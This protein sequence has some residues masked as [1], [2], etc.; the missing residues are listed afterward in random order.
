MA[1]VN[2]VLAT[3]F[4]NTPSQ[5]GPAEWQLPGVINAPV[6]CMIDSYTPAGTEASGTIIRF[7]TD[8]VNQTLSK[9]I[10]GANILWFDIIMAGSTSS[11][12]LSLGDRFLATRYASASTG[13]AT[14]GITRI[15]G[16]VSTAAVSGTP[17]IIGT[18][19]NTAAFGAETN[20]DDQI[21]I[22]TGGATLSSTTSIMTLMMFY[23]WTN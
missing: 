22:T 6:R 10:Q 12:T 16:C 8:G 1:T 19:P 20:G 7:F 15:S 2:S 4:T 5:G 13:P 23:T 9:V 21:I 3:A 11:L 14:A 17:Y 18:N